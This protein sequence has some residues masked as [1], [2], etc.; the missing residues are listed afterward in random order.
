MTNSTKTGI[1]GVAIGVL[2]TII[3]FLVY[4]KVHTK[5]V[6]P[7]PPPVTQTIQT[8]QATQ[9]PPSAP[10]ASSS[11]AQDVARP[12]TPPA[13]NPPVAVPPPLEVKKK[14]IKPQAV[15]R[16]FPKIMKGNFAMVGRGEDAK[17][18][19]GK[20]ANFQYNIFILAESEIISKEALKNG[21]IKV[22]EIRTFNKVQDSIVVSNVDF[23]L[24]ID[25]L[26]IDT[27]SKMIDGVAVGYTS[28][29]GD[30]AGGAAIVEGK[31]YLEEKLRSIDGTSVR[32]LLG[33]VGFQP[34]PDIE[35]MLNRM[36]SAQFTKALGVVR[37]ISGKSYKITYYQEKNG[38]PLMVT[39]K[40]A[41]G[42]EITEEEERM[43]LKR[44]NA[45]ID[46]NVVPDGE[47]RPGD[48]W[49]IAAED[50][51]EVFDPFVDGTYTGNIKAIRKSNA[52]NGDWSI[53]MSPSSINVVADNGA[54]T[55][56]L[57]LN[58]GYAFVNPEKLCV[59]EMFVEGKAKLAKTSRH[60][61]L[62]TARIDGLCDF[63]GRIVTTSKGK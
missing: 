13:T 22:E 56:S 62:F 55:G 40:H 31:R 51:Q 17:W 33:I 7:V 49:S 12:T 39:F 44:I 20:V 47:C 24:A 41:D 11:A 15:D 53:A 32:Q 61:L 59:N 18:G 2:V 6:P 3:A 54:T 36:A 45:F 27:F 25:T 19:I 35:A 5:P 42:S 23:K 10:K 14:P 52:E 43:I 50:M 37:S 58:R 34:T 63:Q 38:Q 1:I 57:Q 48:S 16:V 9:P 8:P 60:H 29:T 21:T 26:P 46:Y 30:A 28:F 4:D